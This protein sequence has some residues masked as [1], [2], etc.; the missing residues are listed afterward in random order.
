MREYFAHWAELDGEVDGAAWVAHLDEE[1]GKISMCFPHSNNKYHLFYYLLLSHIP[2]RQ[3]SPP[4]RLFLHSPPGFSLPT[5]T[6]GKSQSK[7]SAEQLADLQKNTYCMCFAQ[8]H[9]FFANIHHSRQERAPAMVC[10]DSVNHPLTVMITLSQV[11]RFSQ[12]LSFWHA[13]QGRVLADIQTILSIR[14]SCRIC[15]LCI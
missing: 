10:R 15:R 12:R 5:S 2:V 11:Q 13:R 7:L 8:A 9:H 3:A 14:R 1:E 6:M 4:I